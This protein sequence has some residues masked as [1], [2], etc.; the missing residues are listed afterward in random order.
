MEFEAS[1]P[2]DAIVVVVAEGPKD[3]SINYF[4]M[5]HFAIICYKVLKIKNIL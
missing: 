3:E 4:I 1:A 2:F 5:L